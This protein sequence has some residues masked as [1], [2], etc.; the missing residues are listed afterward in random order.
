M[1][2]HLTLHGAFI[3]PHNEAICLKI[4]MEQR[5]CFFFLCQW[6]CLYASRSKHF[7]D[8]TDEKTLQCIQD[9]VSLLEKIKSKEV[10]WI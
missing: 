10:K 6:Q 7:H 2:Q 1:K 3:L 8:V 4:D 9:V 5:N